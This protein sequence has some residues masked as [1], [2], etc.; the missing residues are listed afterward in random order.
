M[1]VRE[2]TG[3]GVEGM[4]G[5]GLGKGEVGI[6]CRRENGEEGVCVKVETKRK[7]RRGK[8]DKERSKQPFTFPGQQAPFLPWTPRTP[9]F[10]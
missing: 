2:R 9:A 6:D 1:G 7:E 8:R 3:R 4:T 10:G 5:D